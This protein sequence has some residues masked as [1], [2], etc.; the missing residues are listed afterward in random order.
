MTPF[1]EPLYLALFDQYYIFSTSDKKTA[2][3]QKHA[4]VR[5]RDFVQ[6]DN[7]F[8]P[9]RPLFVDSEAVNVIHEQPLNTELLFSEIDTR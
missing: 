6:Y 9:L 2:M 3:V 1:G 7:L 8:R 5:N 4:A